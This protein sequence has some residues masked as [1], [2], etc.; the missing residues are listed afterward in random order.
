MTMSLEDFESAH[1]PTKRHEGIYARFLLA[2]E[3]LAP[4]IFT[5]QQGQKVKAAQ[6]KL[7]A[8]WRGGAASVAVRPVKG[9]VV[10]TAIIDGELYVVW[11]PSDD[12]GAS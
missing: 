10:R 4:T 9:G 12:G 5:L 6:Q 1:H 8:Q 2:L 11:Y 7:L 3:P